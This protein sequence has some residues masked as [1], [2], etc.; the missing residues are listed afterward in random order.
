MT[1]A[2]ET[3]TRRLPDLELVDREAALPRKSVLRAPAALR[4]RRRG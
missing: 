2:L 4:V 3:L 1:V